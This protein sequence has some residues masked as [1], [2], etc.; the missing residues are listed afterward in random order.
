MMRCFHEWILVRMDWDSRIATY[1][2]RLCGELKQ[3]PLKE[4]GV[5]MVRQGN[6]IVGLLGTVK[7]A[8]GVPVEEV[9]R[10]GTTLIKVT[11][12]CMYPNGSRVELFLFYD[13]SRDDFYV[14]DEGRASLIWMPSMMRLNY[15]RAVAARYG[16]EFSR[17]KE[18]F[19]LRGV[20]EEELSEAIVKV[21]NASQRLADDLHF[22]GRRHEPQ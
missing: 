18:C 12:Q 11:T 13:D 5:M 22:Q 1:R 19:F 16:V 14:N 8:V 15:G 4:R 20:K 17:A 7:R 6:V 21:A 9:H 3:S 10:W 2:C